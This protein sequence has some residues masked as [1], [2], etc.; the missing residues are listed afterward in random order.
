MPR[1]V[2]CGQPVIGIQAED[3]QTGSEDV[4]V[5]ASNFERS[6]SPD[7]RARTD[8]TIAIDGQA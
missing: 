2:A 3:A 5:D 7:R 6:S 8:R 4:L 1:E